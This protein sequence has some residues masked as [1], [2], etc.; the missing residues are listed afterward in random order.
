MRHQKRHDHTSS[1]ASLTPVVIS[2]TAWCRDN[3][4]TYHTSVFKNFFGLSADDVVDVTFASTPASNDRRCSASSLITAPPSS[5]SSSSA[6]SS[7]NLDTSCSGFEPLIGCRVISELD[8]TGKLGP[9]DDKVLFSSVD[10]EFVKLD[11]VGTSGG[12]GGGDDECF[13]KMSLDS[14]FDVSRKGSILS[15]QNKYFYWKWLL[16]QLFHNHYT[17]EKTLT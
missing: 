14:S 9:G 4:T 17:E 11:D 2:I 5:S 3:V 7:A 1:E 8:L 13:S 6:S 12:S 16:Y 15:N 10:C